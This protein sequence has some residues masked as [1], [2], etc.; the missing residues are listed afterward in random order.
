MADKHDSSSAQSGQK[1]VSMKIFA[2]VEV[3]K[4]SPNCVPRNC[5]L[6]LTRLMV[7]KPL[8]NE[9]TSVI[10]AMK[11]QSSK[12]VLRSNEIEMPISGIADVPLDISFSLQYPH[13]LKRDGNKLQVMLQRRKRYKNRPII[14]YKTLA[15]GHL[16]MAEVLQ[17]SSSKELSLYTDGKDHKILVAK[18]GMLNISSTPIDK[19]ENQNGRR[20]PGASDVDRSPDIDADSEEDENEE[21]NWSND[22]MSD[23]EPTMLDDGHLRKRGVGRSKVRPTMNR[24]RNLKQKFVA[25]LKRFKISDEVLDAEADNVLGDGGNPGDIEDLI[26]QL[27]D[28]SDSDP[29]LDTMSVMSTPKP[30]L[31]PFFT[32]KGSTHDIDCQSLTEDTLRANVNSD[33]SSNSQAERDTDPEILEAPMSTSLDVPTCRE[34]VKSEPY[35]RNSHP[36]TLS[37]LQKPPIQRERSTS[38]KEKAEK[39]SNRPLDRCNSTGWVD[40]SPR[41]VLLDQLSSVLGASDDKLPDS[42]FLVN[43]ADWQGQLLVQKLQEKPLR[44]I[45]TCSEADV[46]AAVNGIVSKIQKFCNF[47]SR[48]PHAIKLVISGGDSYI[49]SVLRPYV[50]QFA[51]KSPDWQNY[52]KFLVIP[53]GSSMLGKYLAHID[54]TYGNLFMDYAWKET[55]DKTEV[56]KLE[57]QEVYNRVSKYLSTAGGVTQIPIAEAM[58]MCKGKGSDEESNQVFVPF[59]CEV[60]V[61]NVELMMTSMDL[62][63]QAPQQPGTLSSSPPQNVLTVDKLLSTPPNTPNVSAI[64]PF[65]GLTPPSASVPQ[66]LAG[67]EYVE[68]Q[69]DYWTGSNKP[70]ST[71]KVD[72]SSKKD[73]NK[74]SLKSAFK[75][76][77]VSRIGS[78]A[79]VHPLADNQTFPFQ[80]TVVTREKKQKIRIG[81]K[82]KEAENKTAI[83]EGI[84]RLICTSK[85]LNHSLKVTVD[86]VDWPGVKFFQLSSQWQTH[87]KQFPVCVFINDNT[88]VT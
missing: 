42:L 24:Q 52:V 25:L 78:T 47:N 3:E 71:D 17:H 5:S 79:P 54:S 55:F 88:Q 84:S 83:Y 21:E 15:I 33:D 6:R 14:G 11:M 44:V 9:L 7:L 39:K 46:R 10:I 64:T 70:E 37:T 77:Q 57:S 27:E 8:E 68:L 30:R 62:E 53:L 86:G 72:K 12:R 20:K 59:L 51:A 69:V 49:N 80:L 73:S 4:S 32:G 22:E 38:Y 74:V 61:G 76:L 65:T 58:V 66:S 23:S 34:P 19:E 60:K 67:R 31:R 63:E 82:S 36:Q 43:T 2:S 29:D 18:V 75:Y 87:I 1:V 40:Q 16:N 28:L 81:K 35:K 41:K 48:S 50:E 45:C 56:S 26:E 13:F 85:T